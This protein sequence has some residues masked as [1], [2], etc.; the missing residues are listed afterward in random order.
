M[1][2]NVMM[3]CAGLGILL[4][5][6]GQAGASVFITEILADPPSG[7]A[8]DSNGDG[9]TSSRDDE[10]IELFNSSDSPISLGG[11]SISDAIN[12][13]HIFE[14]ET[15]IGAYEYWVVFGG[16]AP[17]LSGIRW[18]AASSGALSLNNSADT[19]TL[20]NHDFDI[21]DQVV[22]G[23]MAGDNQ[24][25]VRDNLSENS[26]FSK[27]TQA[28]SSGELFTPGEGPYEVKVKEQVNEAAV[29]PE[30]E[31]ALTFLIGMAGIALAQRRRSGMML[32][33]GVCPQFNKKVF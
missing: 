31:T 29:I 9:I 20:F 25:I 3:V 19:I 33:N 2:L 17:A 1:R 7:L 22:Y 14:Q 4:F 12:T 11:W 24:S 15:I 26:K 6:G 13:R 5:M 28:D 32:L 23:A 30:T 27:I 18:Q 8:G 21:M 16:G 10:F